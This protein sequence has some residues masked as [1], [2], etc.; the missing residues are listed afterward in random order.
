[1][2]SPKLPGQRNGAGQNGRKDK[3]WDA[4]RQGE[5]CPG[6]RCFC[7]AER[8]T[9]KPVKAERSVWF[10]GEWCFRRKPGR[11]RLNATGKRQ[12]A[13]EKKNAPSLCR[14][15]FR[16]RSGY[17]KACSRFDKRPFLGKT[18]YRLDGNGFPAEARCPEGIERQAAK[19]GAR[20]APFLY[21]RGRFSLRGSG[22]RLRRC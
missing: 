20:S 1:M 13:V 17:L 4:L 12:A 8:C 18:A 15:G 9:G 10:W 3:A 7:G 5:R 14:S 16:C 11:D 22:C 21:C 6:G 19:K 2:V